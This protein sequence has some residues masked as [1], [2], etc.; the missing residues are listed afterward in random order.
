MKTLIFRSYMNIV[1]SHCAIRPPIEL[2]GSLFQ[3]VARLG[4]NGEDDLYFDTV[5][6]RFYHSAHYAYDNW[7]FFDTTLNLQSAEEF[8][9]K[10]PVGSSVI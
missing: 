5:N 1:H 7:A 10:Y 9:E 4:G 8:Q 3:A 6:K 2:W